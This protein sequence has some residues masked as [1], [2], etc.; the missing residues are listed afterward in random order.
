MVSHES[1][2]PNRCIAKCFAT[3]R[4]SSSGQETSRLVFSLECIRPTWS[5]KTSESTPRSNVAIVNCLLIPLN[6]I[7]RFLSNWLCD[8]R[9]SRPWLLNA[10]CINCNWSRRVYH[11]DT[12]LQV[13]FAAQIKPLLQI[14]TFSLSLSLSIQGYEQDQQL[15]RTSPTSVHSI[16]LSVNRVVSNQ[17]GSICRKVLKV[18]SS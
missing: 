8:L 1:R 10:T 16:Q 7:C 5:F 9:T 12:W 15:F 17:N 3:N 4:R 14:N 18:T 6:S 11:G 2:W 13:S